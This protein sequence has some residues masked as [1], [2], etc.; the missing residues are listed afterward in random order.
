MEKHTFDRRPQKYTSRY[1]KL[2]S[3]ISIRVANI[4]GQDGGVVTPVKLPLDLHAKFGHLSHTMC[5]PVGGP[6]IWGMLRPRPI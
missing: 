3:R 6:K 1:R 2:I 5:A 4:F